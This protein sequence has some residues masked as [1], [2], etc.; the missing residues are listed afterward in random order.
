MPLDPEK[1]VFYKSKFTERW[2]MEVPMASNSVYTR[3]SI[4]PCSYSD[5]QTATK[6][7]IPDRY[8]SAL[9]KG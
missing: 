6:G 5:Y 9:S 2:W 3:N 8:I 4:V 1:L 7:E